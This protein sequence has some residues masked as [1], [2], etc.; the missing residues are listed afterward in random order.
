MTAMQLFVYRLDERVQCIGAYPRRN[1]CF[2]VLP[3]DSS[4]YRLILLSSLVLNL[5]AKV[6]PD[7][8][9]GVPFLLRCDSL[10]VLLVSR[11]LC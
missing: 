5:F 10:L 9:I 8:D 7:L 11:L 3:L 1:G 6:G 4:T 2:D